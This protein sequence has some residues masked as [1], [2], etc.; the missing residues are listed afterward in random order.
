[1]KHITNNTLNMLFGFASLDE[2]KIKNSSISKEEKKESILKNISATHNKV[3][4]NTL[5]P[6]K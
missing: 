6:K 4:E 2:I 3:G 1:M 5:P